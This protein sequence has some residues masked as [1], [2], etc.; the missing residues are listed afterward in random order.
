MDSLLKAPEEDPAAR[1]RRKAMERQADRLNE[2]ERG[3]VLADLTRQFGRM[4]GTPKSAATVGGAS[5][6]QTGGGSTFSGGRPR[7]TGTLGDI[8]GG[9]ARRISG[10]GY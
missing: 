10:T 8:G 4:Y 2:E 9:Y 7:G 6:G 3:R 5:G 1:R